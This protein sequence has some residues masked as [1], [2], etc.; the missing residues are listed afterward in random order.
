MKYKFGAQILF[1]NILSLF[2]LFSVSSLYFPCS[3]MK[4]SWAETVSSCTEKL[5]EGTCTEKLEKGTSLAPRL[6]AVG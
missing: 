2:I 1:I 6:G 5:E 4:L 3:T